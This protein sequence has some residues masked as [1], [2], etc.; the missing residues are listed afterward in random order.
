MV[1]KR[2]AIVAGLFYLLIG[3]AGFFPAMLAAPDTAHHLNLQVLQGR[4]FGLFP[5]NV[6]HTLVHLA[7]GAWGLWAARSSDHACAVYARSLAILFAVLAVMGLFPGLD[8]VFGL[9]PLHAHDI[10]LHAIT[11]GVAAYAG[12]Y[13]AQDM[14]A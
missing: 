3:I 5:V 9:L 1:T 7:V 13:A 12:W 8:N 11:A 14:R 4:L 10:W 2:F 6:A